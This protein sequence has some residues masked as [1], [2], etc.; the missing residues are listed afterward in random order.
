MENV[1]VARGGAEASLTAA[2]RPRGAPVPAPTPAPR[3]RPGV[4]DH[5]G[6]SGEYRPPTSTRPR[7]VSDC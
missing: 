2:R 7:T 3:A 6:K 4:P 5:A 1:R